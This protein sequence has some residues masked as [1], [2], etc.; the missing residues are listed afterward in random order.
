MTKGFEELRKGEATMKLR[1]KADWPAVG[2]Q[3]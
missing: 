1:T 3:L 2:G